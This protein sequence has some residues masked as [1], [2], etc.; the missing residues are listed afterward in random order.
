MLSL[1]DD[2]T[3]HA[4]KELRLSPSRVATEYFSVKQLDSS[5]ESSHERT[6]GACLQVKSDIESLCLAA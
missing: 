6:H 4:G 2:V 1:E 5:N 3:V